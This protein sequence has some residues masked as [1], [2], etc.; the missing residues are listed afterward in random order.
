LK[1]AVDKGPWLLGRA[2][3][4]NKK[5]SILLPISPLLA[6]VPSLEV[7]IGE[8]WNGDPTKGLEEKF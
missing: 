1:V 3:G 8:R 5:A 2:E 6:P 7:E 4:H